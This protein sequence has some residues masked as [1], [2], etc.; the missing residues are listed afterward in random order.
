MER[1]NLFPQFTSNWKLSVWL[2]SGRNKT[3]GD[4]F[5]LKYSELYA[6]ATV[7]S[8]GGPSK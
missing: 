7:A 1:S 2:E 6:Y 8:G 5:M 3:M 4:F